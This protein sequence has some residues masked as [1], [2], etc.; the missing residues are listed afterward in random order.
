MV[1]LKK[2]PATTA[3]SNEDVIKHTDEQGN[4]SLYE[5]A[6]SYNKTANEENIKNI[7]KN[8]NIFELI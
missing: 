3:Y 4:V 2:Q 7:L 6:A 1:T 8:V 5:T